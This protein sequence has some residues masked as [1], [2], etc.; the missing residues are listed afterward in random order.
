MINNK[1]ILLIVTGGI[2]ACKTPELI[3]QLTKAGA[4]VRVIL[5]KGG[6]QFVTPMTLGALSGDTVYQD[7]FSLTDEN[8][9]GHIELSRDADLVVVAPATADIMA[10]MAAGLTDDLASTTLLATDKPVIIAPSMNVRMW[11]HPATRNN[12]KTLISRGISVIGPEEGDMACGEYGMGRMSEPC[13]ITETVERF[14]SAD[15]RLSGFRALVTSGPTHEAIDP[16]RFLANR[17]SGKQGHAIARALAGL[18]ADTTLITGPTGLADLS[19]VAMVHVE[20]ARDMLA[21]CQSVL[22]SDIAVCAA[23]VADW[24]VADQ[25]TRK[26]KKTGNAGPPPLALCENPDILHILGHGGKRRPGLLIGFAAETDNVID[27]GRLKREQK[28]C[29]WI[30]ANNVSPDSGTFGG[31]YNTIH[32]IHRDGVED[33]PRLTKDQVAEKLADRIAITLE[34]TS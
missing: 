12:V 21:A 22:P 14:F 17:S 7:L 1:R 4:R 19:G 23:A 16:V 11:E 8:T 29:D 18:G 13:D 20:S 3:R 5:S 31:D 10:K 32:F 34:R 28:N 25:A 15:G 26:I 2:A 33:W 24:R 9:M 27:H 6:A 30:L